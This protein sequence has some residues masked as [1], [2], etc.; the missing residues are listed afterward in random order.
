M[1]QEE[2]APACASPANR[3]HGGMGPTREGCSGDP[4]SPDLYQG[5]AGPQRALQ[6][7]GTAGMGTAPTRAD[8]CLAGS[9]KPPAQ[10]QSQLLRAASTGGVPEVRG[11][12]Q[13]RG[14]MV[15]RPMGA[16]LSL[17]E[18]LVTTM[19]PPC[20]QGSL[21]VP[22]QPWGLAC[23]G[24]PAHP[25]DPCSQWGANL[26]KSPLAPGCCIT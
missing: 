3:L 21:L 2:C 20:P 4:E 7:K 17:G 26:A 12:R 14:S 23:P 22:A 24:V 9:E 18:S 19:H 16:R 6:G 25:W 13:H 11:D 8:Q 15:P 5:V 10:P 1:S